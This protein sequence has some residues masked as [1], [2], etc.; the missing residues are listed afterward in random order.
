[1]RAWAAATSSA[2]E[3]RDP[4]LDRVVAVRVRAALLRGLAGSGGTLPALALLRVIE[5][6]PL[7]CR[8][9]VA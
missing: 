4:A 7:C 1:M 3:A 6:D 9:P 5:R 8:L 2:F